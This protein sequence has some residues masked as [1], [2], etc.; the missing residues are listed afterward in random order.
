VRRGGQRWHLVSSAA[1]RPLGR[2]R[3]LAHRGCLLRRPYGVCVEASG[4]SLH[5]GRRMIEI[6][7]CGP[8]ACTAWLYAFIHELGGTT[9]QPCDE[10]FRCRRDQ[11]GA[12]NHTRSHRVERPAVGAL[13]RLIAE[14]PSIRHTEEVAGRLGEGRWGRIQHRY[15]GSSDPPDAQE[16]RAQPSTGP[17]G[18]VRPRRLR[19]HSGKR[20]TQCF[21]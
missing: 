7:V 5:S 6:E 14:C 10:G 20:R 17:S 2:A 16:G 3:L 1:R 12:A 18:H 21:T 15:C 8:W 13:G 4:R 11:V 9:P 19:P